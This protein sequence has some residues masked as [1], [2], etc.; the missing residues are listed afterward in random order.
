LAFTWPERLQLRTV[1]IDGRSVRF[2]PPAAGTL[3]LPFASSAPLHWVVLEW[4]SKASA[5]RLP[6]AAQRASIPLP[7][8]LPVE[9]SLISIVPKNGR[10]ISTR[11]GVTTIRRL[12]HELSALEGLIELNEQSS[13]LTGRCDA[14][15]LARAQAILA[16]LS[17]PG[18]DEEQAEDLDKRISTARRRLDALAKFPTRE[19]ASVAGA[20]P[21]VAE[22]GG[23]A[24]F[25]R[26]APG[27]ETSMISVWVLNLRGLWIALALVG[28]L[29][30]P[31]LV[32]LLLGS[33]A[34]ELLERQ[35]AL[36]IGLVA[37]VWWLC[38]RPSALGLL[39]ALVAIAVAF[40]QRRRPRA[41]AGSGGPE[42][43]S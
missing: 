13:R 39:L 14:R 6:L 35:P 10:E 17:A 28:L 36:A 1:L 5:S 21:D 42:P 24:V 38:L 25:A 26:V 22:L 2:D 29:V 27:S 23:D 4:R 12:D 37:L 43:A 16:A 31:R 18:V 20:V 32:R 11:S 41:A 7:A 8:Q 33:G 19:A 15:S 40:V 9:R 34:P 3:E 30:L